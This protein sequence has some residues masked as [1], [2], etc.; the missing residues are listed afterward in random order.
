V[1]DL[2]IEKCFHEFIS[3]ISIERNLSENTV[4]AYGGDLKRFIKFVGNIDIKQIKVGEIRKFVVSQE[5]SKYKDRTIKRRIATLKVFFSFSVSSGFIQIS[6]LQNIK[7]RYKTIQ[8]LPKVMSAN[9]VKKLLRSPLYEIQIITTQ[10]PKKFPSTNTALFRAYR[11]RAILELLFATGMRIGELVNINISDMNLRERTVIILGKGR[12]ER[13]IYLS[14]DEVLNSIREYINIRKK[15]ICETNALF[16][17]KCETRLSIFSVENI[18]RKHHRLARIKRH[19]TPH[20][21]RHTMA[22]MLLNNGADIRVVQEILGHA[23]ILT[24]QIYTEVSPKL[25][26]KILLKYHQRN[27]MNIL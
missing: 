9:E 12:K 20:C 7:R 4:K 3:S 26:R 5:D 19:Y 11:N 14:N 27:K 1:T 15:I 22:T 10:Y 21:L 18:F 24:T 2:R 23:S 6:P 16:L 13:I 17:N 25:K 8:R